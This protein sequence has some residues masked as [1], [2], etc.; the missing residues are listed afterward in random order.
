METHGKSIVTMTWKRTWKEM[1]K[2][3]KLF[4]ISLLFISFLFF[5]SSSSSFF[6]RIMPQRS[7][8]LIKMRERRGREIE[9]TRNREEHKGTE[10]HRDIGTERQRDREREGERE[11]EC[12]GE[13]R[14]FQLIS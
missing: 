13:R 12:V 10:R 6:L 2:R 3:T 1:A 7:A 4:F 5:I 9:G 8:I 11:R 14:L